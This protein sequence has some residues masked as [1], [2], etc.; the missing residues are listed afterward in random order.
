MEGHLTIL[1]NL[2]TRLRKAHL[3]VKP[4]KCMFGFT[5]VAFLGHVVGDSIL[6]PSP[7]KLI[8]I[9]RCPRPTT[10]K[11]VRSFLGLVGVLSEV[12]S[13]LQCYSL[14]TDRSSTER[15]SKYCFVVK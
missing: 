12:Y 11:Q 8:Q 5:S 14:S 10:K 4:S 6:M 3:T 1:R 15:Q 9:Q 13:K 7:D 2:L